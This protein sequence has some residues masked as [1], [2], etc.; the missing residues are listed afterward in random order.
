MVISTA[1]KYAEFSSG[2]REVA[3]V[4]KLHAVGMEAAEMQR[5][6]E[7]HLGATEDAA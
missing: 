3:A 6:V 5:A 1:Y 2:Q 4:K 7:D